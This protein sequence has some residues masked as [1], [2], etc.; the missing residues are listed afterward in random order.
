[1]YYFEA[2]YVDRSGADGQAMAWESLENGIPWEVIGADRTMLGA[3]LNTP[4][5]TSP[6]TALPTLAPTELPTKNAPTDVPTPPAW[7]L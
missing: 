5:P 7:T 2:L 1:M 4:Q 3:D 6:P